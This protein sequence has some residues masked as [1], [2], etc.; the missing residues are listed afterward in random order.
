MYTFACLDLTYIKYV[1]FS[2][3]PPPSA[4]FLSVSLSIYGELHFPFAE[5]S[6]FPFPLFVKEQA[7]E[8]RKRQARNYAVPEHEHG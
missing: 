1:F 5:L 6:S 2:V 3:F 8:E 7:V 4:Y